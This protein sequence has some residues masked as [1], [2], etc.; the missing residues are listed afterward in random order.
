MLVRRGM[1][2]CGRPRALEQLP[3]LP[4]PGHVGQ[5]R[6][7][8]HAGHPLADFLFDPKQ[9]VLRVLDQDQPFRPPRGQL[10][11]EL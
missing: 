4:R 7:D 2:D 9:R 3:H 1:E 8:P 6:L 5:D 10:A 11:H